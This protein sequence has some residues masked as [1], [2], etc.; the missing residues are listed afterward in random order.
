MILNHSKL[1]Y[2]DMAYLQQIMG[3]VFTNKKVTYL[4]TVKGRINKQIM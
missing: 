2:N 1:Y 3:K 4:S